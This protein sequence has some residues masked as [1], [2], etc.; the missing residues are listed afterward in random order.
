MERLA[1]C[2]KTLY[3]VD[4]LN[5]AREIRELKEQLKRPTLEYPSQC[6]YY[7]AYATMMANIKRDCRQIFVDDRVEFNYA[8]DNGLAP[9]QANYLEMVIE[10]ELKKVV[11]DKNCWCYETAVACVFGLQ[12]MTYA[13]VEMGTWQNHYQLIGGRRGW[14]DTVISYVD[15]YM[16]NSLDCL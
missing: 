6:E 7:A 14:Y 13:L 2:S 10:A 11:D 5:K 9:R 3:D 12:T 16:E 15:K 8:F 1:V 4:I